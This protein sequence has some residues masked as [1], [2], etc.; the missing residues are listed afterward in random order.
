MLRL[1]NLPHAVRTLIKSPTLVVVAT[2]SLG[3]GIG[4]N[5]T[6]Y[7]LFRVVFS[8]PPTAVAPDRLV[9]VEPGNGNQ[10]SYPN[11]RGL[12]P[13]GT[14]EGLAAYALTRLN[15]R[16]GGA[17]EQ[18]LS[19]LVSPGFFELLGV[20]PAMGRTLASDTDA[21]VITAAFW[22][23]RLHERPD[24]IGAVIALNGHA[25]TV[26]GVLPDGYRAV[27][28]ALGPD[29]YVPISA[30]LA[31]DLDN[32]RR[33]FLTLLVR[34]RPDAS[35]RQAGDE[36]R[37]QMQAIERSHPEGNTDF[38]RAAFL[39]PVSGLASWQTRDM[40]TMALFG[41]TSVPFVIF[42]LVLLIACA[43]VAG[44]LLAR[45]AA[46]R[47]E[48]AIRL[49]L[50]ASRAQVVATLLAESLVLSLLGALA[51]LLLTHWLC[52]IVSAM[53]LPQAAGS[54]QVSPDLTVL[55]YALLLAFLVTLS[56]GLLPALAS[57][58]PQ[59]TDALRRE[60]AESRRRVTSRGVLV[61]GQIAVASLLLFLSIL[62]LRSLH[63]IREVDPG[64]SIDEVFTAHV[65]LDQ[66][67][68]PADARLRVAVEALEAARAVPGIASATLT[69]MIPL[70]GD[71]NS[72]V[73]H[74]RGPG[75]DPSGELRDARRA[76]L[77]QDHGDSRAARA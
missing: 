23:R 51:G 5:T 56:C 58:R 52:R 71:V 24:P 45:G 40:P 50:G 46:R 10:I 26:V 76:R 27:T 13:G 20:R 11:V 38:G 29:V 70:G 6:L 30:A 8:Q 32:R 53:P 1:L 74:P 33:G 16:G 54:L 60:S 77:L 4:V 19:L 75:R 57:T 36:I 47:R 44:L 68:Y 22:R 14:F 69:N 37:A 65:D 15:L 12:V 17:D 42:G 41:I 31:P 7:S 49:A 62:V 9:R 21:A 55:N 63:F 48:I 18:V 25:H 61:S 34:L 35:L 73:L 28:G 3:L 43:N 39:F 67:R 64:F 72:T 66:I 2:L 59:V